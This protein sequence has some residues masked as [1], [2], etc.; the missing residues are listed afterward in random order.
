MATYAQLVWFTWPLWLDCDDKGGGLERSPKDTFYDLTMEGT[1]HSSCSQFFL[2][3]CVNSQEMILDGRMIRKNA[4]GC[5]F[6]HWAQWKAGSEVC[7]KIWI[8]V[9]QFVFIK[10]KSESNSVVGTG[11]FVENLGMT[12]D[13]VVERRSSNDAVCK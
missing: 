2:D 11:D 6:G 8:I 12:V 1:G 5:K 10:M 13:C 4:G 7:H 9:G 3:I